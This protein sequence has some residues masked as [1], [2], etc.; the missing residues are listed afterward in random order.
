[1]ASSPHRWVVV[2]AVVAPVALVGGWTWG[3]ARQPPGYSA[4]SQTISA[5]AAR[6][7]T[8]R[9]IM[10]AGL[11]LLGLAHVG[12]ALGLGPAV[13]TP[14]RAVLA[15]GGLA[16]LAVALFPQPAGD[17]SSAAHVTSAT[18][19]FV[20]L[21]VWVALAVDRSAAW[22]LRPPATTVATVVLAGL[23]VTF[24]LTISG[25]VVGVTER[26]LAAAQALWP[27]VAVAGLLATRRPRPPARPRSA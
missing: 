18:V 5:L 13:R 4:V 16:T 14:A 27:L 8:D 15:L 17:G 7:A 9:W 21:T 10:T 23:L 6:D 22:P 25:D 24:G 19:G 11:A 2:P 1:M 20:A 12:T 26:L 3:V